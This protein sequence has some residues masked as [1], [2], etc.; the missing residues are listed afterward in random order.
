MSDGYVIN[1]WD[2]RRKLYGIHSEVEDLERKFFSLS[3]PPVIANEFDTSTEEGSKRLNQMLFTHYQGDTMSVVPICTCGTLTGGWNRGLVCSICNTTC[4]NS[5]ERE[6][7][8]ALWL[9]VPQGV[10]AFMNPIAWI[11][12]DNAMT[13]SGFS[14]LMWL[15][16]PYYRPNVRVPQKVRKFEEI[17]G[18]R[19]GMNYFIHNFDILMTACFVNERQRKPDKKQLGML[20]FLKENR[21]KIFT[22]YIPMPTNVAFVI[23]ENETGIYA[24]TKNMTDAI[25]A[26]R[27]VMATDQ[28][29]TS[30]GEKYRESKTAVAMDKISKFYVNYFTNVMSKKPGTWRKHVYGGRLFFTGRAVISSLSDVHHYQDLILPWG[31]SIQLMEMQLKSLLLKMIDVDTGRRYTPNKI[32]KILTEAITAYNLLIDSLFRRLIAES[33]QGRGIP[34]L[35]QRNPTLERAAAQLFYVVAVKTDPH[36]V[37][38]AMPT[39]A[40]TGPNAD[41]DGD[42]LNLLLILDWKMHQKLMGFSPWMSAIDTTRPRSVSRNLLLPAPMVSTLLNWMFKGE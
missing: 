34:V 32:S 27:I 2:Q 41:Y 7:E 5:T 35:L 4:Q 29:N 16:D 24:D 19:R 30:R 42:E 22:R 31:V 1:P 11:I 18:F 17:P 39:T 3:K 13:L 25:D 36:D 10:T 12:L 20:Q 37:T 6:M 38:I 28:G 15:T 9:R 23:E 26:L 33:P 14:F 8:S 21:N 40:L